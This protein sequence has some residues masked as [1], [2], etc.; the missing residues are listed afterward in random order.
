L[1]GKPLSPNA[2]G[3]TDEQA[4]AIA[5]NLRRYF[6]LEAKACKLP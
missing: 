6:E 1:A 2:T 4:T 3:V 5:K